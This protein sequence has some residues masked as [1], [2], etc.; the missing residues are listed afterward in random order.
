M[1]GKAHWFKYRTF[2][3]GLAPKTWQGWVYVAVAAFLLAGTLAMGVAD[4]TKMWLFAIILVIFLVDI[5]VIMTQLP[6]VTDERE[7]YHQL[8]IERNCSFAAIAALLAVAIYQTYKN[9]GFLASQNGTMP[10]DVSLL[11]VLGAMF[12]VKVGSTIYVKMKL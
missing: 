12:V 10:F 3:W 5:L 1:I 7:N 4:S 9:T 2:G 11:I 6:K 8:I